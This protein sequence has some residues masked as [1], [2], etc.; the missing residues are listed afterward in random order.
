[1]EGKASVIESLSFGDSGLYKT[2]IEILEDSGVSLK[3][4]EVGCKRWP[5]EG[6]YRFQKR[7]CPAVSASSR[8]LTTRETSYGSLGRVRSHA[9]GLFKNHPACELHGENAHKKG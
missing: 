8:R 7:E 6:L 2:I 1:M 3:P 9:N 5:L 4:P